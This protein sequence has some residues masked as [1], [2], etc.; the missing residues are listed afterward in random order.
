VTVR[1]TGTVAR[2][3]EMR[4][5]AA[6]PVSARGGGGGKTKTAPKWTGPRDMIVTPFTFFRDPPSR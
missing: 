1:G 5:D 3:S 6:R 2:V 4:E